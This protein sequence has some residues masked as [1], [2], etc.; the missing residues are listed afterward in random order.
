MSGFRSSALSAAVLA[1]LVVAAP[2]AAAAPMAPADGLPDGANEVERAYCEQ[3]GH[4]LAC[5]AARD[6]AKAATAEAK[7]RYSADS[8]RNGIGDAYRHCYWN[9]RMTVG[10]G[11]SAAKGF[12]DRHEETPG[13]PV[14]ER[15]MDLHNNAAGRQ[16]GVESKG[17]ASAA[18]GCGRLADGGGLRTLR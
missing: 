16:V 18:A 17:Y 1:L 8:Q 7:E 14:A 11:E 10:M 2:M 5:L 15:E 4:W 12:A 13:Q 9:A 3:P 6:H